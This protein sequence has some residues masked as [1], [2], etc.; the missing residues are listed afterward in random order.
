MIIWGLNEKEKEQEALEYWCFRTDTVPVPELDRE[1]LNELVQAPP[2][3]CENIEDCKSRMVCDLGCKCVRGVFEDV[4]QFN[5]YQA[6]QRAYV[7]MKVFEILISGTSICQSQDETM[8]SK[9]KRPQQ[10]ETTNGKDK[11]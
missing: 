6:I 2:Q 1:T 8:I 4:K 9:K 5:Q 7:K 11:I 3:L 10:G